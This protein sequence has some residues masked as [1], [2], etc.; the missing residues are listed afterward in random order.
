MLCIDSKKFA[1]RSGTGWLIFDLHGGLR[2]LRI[3]PGAT[4]LTMKGYQKLSDSRWNADGRSRLRG[5]NQL[6]LLK[7][8]RWQSVSL[9]R[10]ADI[11]RSSFEPPE[12]DL[13]PDDPKRGRVRDVRYRGNSLPGCALRNLAGRGEHRH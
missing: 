13:D 7:T 10:P 9:D 4:G 5:G 11:Q 6:R 1:P 12:P 3:L 8:T 2:I